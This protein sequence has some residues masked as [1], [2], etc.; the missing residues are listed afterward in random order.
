MGGTS[1]IG[2]SIPQQKVVA[3]RGRRQGAAAPSALP[4]QGCASGYPNAKCIGNALALRGRRAGAAALPATTPPG[5]P[6]GGPP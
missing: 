2:W 4:A 3:L 5:G 1:T 6:P